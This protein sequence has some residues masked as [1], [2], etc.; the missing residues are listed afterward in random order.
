MYVY[1]SVVLI[2]SVWW[3]LVPLNLNKYVK[4]YNSSWNVDL[5]EKTDYFSWTWAFALKN[6]CYPAGRLTIKKSAWLFRRFAMYEIISVYFLYQLMWMFIYSKAMLLK[7]SEYY[8]GSHYKI[9]LSVKMFT[10]S[11][12][13]IIES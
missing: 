13:V 12:K 3:G 5:Q 8:A 2:Y 7:P 1:N 9:F 4:T 6:I 10:V 11:D